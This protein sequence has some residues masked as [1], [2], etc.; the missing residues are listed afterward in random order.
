MEEMS[1]RRTLPGK[2]ASSEVAVSIHVWCLDGKE[3]EREK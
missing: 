2:H 1:T 3:R